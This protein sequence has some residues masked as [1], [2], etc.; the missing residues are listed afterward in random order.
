MYQASLSPVSNRETWTET[1]DV[2]DD[3]GEG[4]DL[5]DADITV[6]VRSKGGNSV[7]TAEIDSGITLNE[8]E[9]GFSWTFTATQM[10]ALCAGTYEIGC[11]VSIDDTTTQLFVGTIQIVDGVVR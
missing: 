6:E 11:I 1:F 5:S 7:L 10:R 9:T 4:V 8:T 3:D 2:I